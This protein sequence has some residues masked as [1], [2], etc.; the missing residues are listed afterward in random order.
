[1]LTKELRW[2]LC[3]SP[4]WKWNSHLEFWHF[5]SSY[6]ATTLSFSLSMSAF[7]ASWWWTLKSMMKRTRALCKTKADFCCDTWE[8]K[9]ITSGMV[10]SSSLESFWCYFRTFFPSLVFRCLCW[11]SSHSSSLC[12]NKNS[13]SI[14]MMEESWFKSRVVRIFALPV[15]K[16]NY[17][18]FYLRAC[19]MEINIFLSCH[20]SLVLWIKSVEQ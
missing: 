9:I 18:V 14:F 16:S 10:H 3:N 2:K 5:S 19:V 11:F 7:A 20:F 12:L 8:W 15:F 1:M 4:I 6:L 17:V 13:F